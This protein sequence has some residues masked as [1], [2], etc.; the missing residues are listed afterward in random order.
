MNALRI[1]IILLVI[2]VVFL[3]S[4]EK[5][6]EFEK[7]LIQPK[8]VVNAIFYSGAKYQYVIVQKSRSILN[9]N[10]YFEAL[11]NANVKLY[12]GDVFLKELNYVGRVD[13]FYNNMAYDVLEKIPYENG[14]FI[15]STLN[16][17][18]GSTYRLEISNDCL[19]YTSP[20]PRDRTR[21]RMPSSA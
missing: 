18:A 17:K 8:I 14:V 10:N 21:S 16:I 11:P 6:I 19:L 3:S 7:D 13:T 12:E 20:S 15:D 5:T 2:S 9:D 1:Q 4:C